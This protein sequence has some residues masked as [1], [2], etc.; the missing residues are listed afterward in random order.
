MRRLLIMTLAVAMLAVSVVGVGVAQEHE[1]P[2]H[3]HILVLG[4]EFGEVDGSFALVGWRRCVDLAAG[5]SVP[6]HA[7]HD[8]LHVGPVNDVLI[9]NA[10]HAVVGTYPLAPWTSCA[11]FDDFLPIIIE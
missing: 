7:H 3:A 6:L 10:G 5:R 9:D 1:V 4:L 11:D 2:D 8:R